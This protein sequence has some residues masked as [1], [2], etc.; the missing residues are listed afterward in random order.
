MAEDFKTGKC[1]CL[2]HDSVR[3]Q[4]VSLKNTGKVSRDKTKKQC[5]LP[6]AKTFGFIVMG[7]YSA[8]AIA[9]ITHRQQTAKRI[10]KHIR[11]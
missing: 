8:H 11:T 10:G 3:L 7:L 4:G 9:Q 5:L 1:I 2:K 6:C